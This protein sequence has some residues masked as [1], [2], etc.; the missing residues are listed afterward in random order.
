MFVVVVVVVKDEK[1][2]WCVIEWLCECVWKL[3][4]GEESD[5]LWCWCIVIV[6]EW[7][8]CVVCVWW[9]V[10]CC[11]ECEMWEWF[12]DFC[13]VCVLWVGRLED[14]CGEVLKEDGYL[15]RCVKIWN[16]NLNLDVDLCDVNVL[17]VV[18]EG[19]ERDWCGV[20]VFVGWIVV[21]CGGGVWGEELEEDWYASD[22]EIFRRS[23]RE[24]AS[25]RSSAV[26]DVVFFCICLDDE[27][28]VC[29]IVCVFYGYWWWVC[30]FLMCV[31]V[32]FSD[33]RIDV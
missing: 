24:R 10:C 5:V 26:V 6:F 4:S 23:A 12:I 29:V 17:F 16:L 28:G 27:D 9:W 30:V 25:G 31:V 11:D 21:W 20:I 1:E 14:W 2:I 13:V 7:L 19:G 15:R 18:K 3:E 8:I 32:Y 33:S 22:R